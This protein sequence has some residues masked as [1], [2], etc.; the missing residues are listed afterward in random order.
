MP[1]PCFPKGHSGNPAGKPK[2]AKDRFPRSAKR[3][4]VALLERFGTDTALLETVLTKGL[5]A[6]PPSSFPYL[7]LVIEQSLAAPEH[8]V[9]MRDA[10]ARKL[11][12]ELH[13]G[14]RNVNPDQDERAVAQRQPRA[15]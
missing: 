10:L 13:P 15:R 3:A 2:G 5:Q 4:V 6:R 12:N 9:D 7:R 11:V 14:P 8:V 1:R